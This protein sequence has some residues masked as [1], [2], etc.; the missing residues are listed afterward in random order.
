MLVGL[1]SLLLILLHI[2]GWYLKQDTGG[3]AA[4]ERVAEKEVKEGKLAKEESRDLTLLEKSNWMMTFN[5]IMSEIEASV[6]VITRW[7]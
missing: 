2:L 4:H 7:F 6:L 1:L 3:H 5:R